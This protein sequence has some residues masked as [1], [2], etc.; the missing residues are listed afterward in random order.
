M[1]TS[2]AGQRLIAA[3]LASSIILG[4]SW[5]ASAAASPNRDACG[6]AIRLADEMA[7]L[8]T[9]QVDTMAS[10]ATATE[11]GWERRAEEMTPG[12][13]GMYADYSRLRLRYR[14][15]ADAC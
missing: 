5:V 7:E 12:I 3:I 8:H 1:G 10:K 6:D 15:A 4:G 11:L 2:H 14:T 9:R 13:D